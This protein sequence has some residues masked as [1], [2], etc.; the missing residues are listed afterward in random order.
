MSPDGSYASLVPGLVAV[1]VGDGVV[2]TAM[3][4]AA[5]TGVTNREH[6][7]AS[8]IVSTGSGV[9]AV[10]GLAILVLLANSGTG[11]LAGEELRVATAEGIRTTVFAIS[12][13]IVVTLL[14][15]LTLRTTPDPRDTGPTSR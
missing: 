10:V 8:G 6:G 12:G 5:A 2:F 4:I 7:V 15:A 9:G 14:L 11:G 13:G 3:F 1:S